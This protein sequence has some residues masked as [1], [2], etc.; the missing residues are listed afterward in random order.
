AYIRDIL[1]HGQKSQYAGFFDINWEHQQENIKGKLLAPFLGGFF[2][3][4]LENGEIRLSFGEDGFTIDYYDNRFPL[5]PESYAFILEPGMEALSDTLGSESAEYLK[6]SGAVSSMKTLALSAEKASSEQ[7]GLAKMLLWE[8]YTANW[9]VRA[10]IDAAVKGYNGTPGNPASFSALEE[11]LGMQNYRLCFWKVGAEEINYRRFFNINELVSVR[12]ET[13]EVFEDTHRLINRMAAEGKFTGIRVDH[14]DGLY[15]PLGYLREL[16]KRIGDTYLA[17]EKILE[18]DEE[19]PEGWPVEGTT[20]YEFLNFTNGLFCRKENVKKMDSV[21]KRFARVVAD[22]RNLV[23][24]KK[25]LIIGKRMAGDVDNL[26]VIMKKAVGMD[27]HGADITSY[28]L[29]RALVEVLAYFPVYRTYAGEA[30]FSAQDKKY[31]NAAVDAAKSHNRGLDYELEFIRKF[32]LLEIS[33]GYGDEQKAMALDLLKRFQ[34]LTGPL[35]AKG[36]EDTF[37][38]IYNRLIS[39]NEVGGS[40]GEF[41]VTGAE[42]HN[43]N[44]RKAEKWPYGINTTATHDTKRGEDAR[45]R[46]NVL[47][48]IPGEWEAKVK[49]WQKINAA[50]P[51]IKI[52]RNDEYLIYQALIGSMPDEGISVEYRQRVKDYMIKAVR[53]AKVYTA[54]IKPDEGYENAVIAFIDRII[55]EGNEARFEKEYAGFFKKISFYGKLNSLSQVLLKTASPGIPDFYQGCELWDY[56]FVDPDNRRRVDYGLRIKMLAAI[57]RQEADTEGPIHGL[58]ADMKDGGVKM[59]LMRRL[60]K[61]RLDNREVFDK[62]GYIPLYAEGRFK[63]NIICFMREYG[64][65]R[66]MALA[67][68]FFTQLCKEGEMPLGA[69]TWKDTFIEIAREHAGEY[70]D[71]ITGRVINV[72]GKLSV[73]EALSAFPCGMMVRKRN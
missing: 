4:T 1:E 36:F 55:G 58:L 67:P 31:I 14:I 25:R 10:H 9:G 62:G 51:R 53:E 11:L 30:G 13:P 61:A 45:A 54:W 2:G 39:L 28:A 44:K 52:D 34:Q 59:F 26:A 66:V 20:G 15:K 16:K 68:R 42:F 72:E 37:L 35:M 48:E 70:T 22:Y 46:I 69:D 60:L 29:K 7:A 18:R 64:E 47:S 27:R 24:A 38:Y 32:L 21:Y 56:S 33:K 23:T 43:Y 71:A 50:P 5:N 6:F 3:E 8:L 63:E 49:A 19:L 57:S 40:P 12:V 65:N 41:G 17:V 73:G